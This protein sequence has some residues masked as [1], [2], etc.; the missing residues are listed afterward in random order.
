MA[1]SEISP[2]KMRLHQ[3]IKFREPHDNEMNES[4]GLISLQEFLTIPGF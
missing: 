1:I 2:F 4:L 3:E